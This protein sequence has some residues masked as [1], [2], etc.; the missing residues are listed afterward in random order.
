MI[1]TNNINF[2]LLDYVCILE[3]K[4]LDFV[5]RPNDDSYLLI[6]SL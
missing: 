4:E 3:K 5:Y 2:K 6:D 1:T